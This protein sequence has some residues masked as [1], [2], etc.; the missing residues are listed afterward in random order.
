MLHTMLMV[1]LY[2]I[3]MWVEILYFLDGPKANNLIPLNHNND[4]FTV[5]FNVYNGPPTFIN[6]SVY[7]LPI[8]TS[9][10]SRLILDGSESMTQ[11]TV[12]I[13]ITHN[14]TDAVYQCFVSSERGSSLP[15]NITCK[16]SV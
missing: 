15:W 6:C 7:S 4:T 10:L 9:T 16:Y 1:S 5:S 12:T 3:N 8:H 13:N 2:V 11:V 14:N